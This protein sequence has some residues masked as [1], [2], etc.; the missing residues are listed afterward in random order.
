MVTDVK[1]LRR[2]WWQQQGQELGE[3]ALSTG[4]RLVQPCPLWP[5]LPIRPVKA[6]LAGWLGPVEQP[7][8][9]TA[10][11]S[12]VASRWHEHDVS[13]QKPDSPREG[14][15]RGALGAEPGSAD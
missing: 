10:C 3:G 1:V 15:A 4:H 11:V 9:S 7:N 6:A 13:L 8:L 5:G 12:P 14:R 2:R